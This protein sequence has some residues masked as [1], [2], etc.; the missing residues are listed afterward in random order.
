MTDNTPPHLQP[1]SVVPDADIKR[2]MDLRRYLRS[3]LA[4]VDPDIAFATL[5]GQYVDV[6]YVRELID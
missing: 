1:W 4:Q 2:L 5:A 3:I 6:A